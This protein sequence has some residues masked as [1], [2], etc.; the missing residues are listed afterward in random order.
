MYL[1][2]QIQPHVYPAQHS[3]RCDCDVGDTQNDTVISPCIAEQPQQPVPEESAHSVVLS[4]AIWTLE[5]Q[6]LHLHQ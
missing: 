6:V 4:C 1:L 3:P 2:E 5:L